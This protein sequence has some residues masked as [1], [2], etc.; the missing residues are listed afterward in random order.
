MKNIQKLTYFFFLLLAGLVNAQSDEEQ[1][2]QPFIRIEQSD[3]VFTDFL[4]SI[5]VSG[6]ARF[7]TIYRD[8]QTQYGDQVT[9]SKNLDFLAYP[10]AAGGNAAGKPLAELKLTAKPSSASEVSIGYAMAHIFTGVSDS[11]TRFAQIRNLINFGGKVNTDYGLFS[12]QAGG[13]VMWTSLSP[14]TMS[15]LEYRPDHFDRLPWDWYTDSW[16]KYTD[17]YNSSVS[18]G[19]EN[20]G[21]VGFQ[22]VKLLGSGL[23]GGIGFKAMYGRT[24]QSVDQNNVDANPPNA[25]IAGRL[26]KD[27]GANSIGINYYSQDGFID[28]LS[29]IHI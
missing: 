4:G 8:M 29:L 1:Q 14:L 13:G 28:N 10:N 19:G 3:S 11:S 5:K 7:Y 6:D 24:N 27:I 9:A 18:L 16:S 20:Y 12:M 26:S 21:A 25:V 22:G 17:F 23:P 15:N 2:G